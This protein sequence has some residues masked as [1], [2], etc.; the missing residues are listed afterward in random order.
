MDQ[1][2]AY[3]DQV[4]LE[5]QQDQEQHILPRRRRELSLEQIPVT[6]ATGRDDHDDHVVGNPIQDSSQEPRPSIDQ[7]VNAWVIRNNQERRMLQAPPGDAI[8]NGWLSYELGHPV[9]DDGIRRGLR[10]LVRE[11]RIMLERRGRRERTEDTF[12]L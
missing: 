4:I 7:Q 5:Q 1:W 11:N 8:R 12:T 9:I 3:F 10:R 2:D 6:I